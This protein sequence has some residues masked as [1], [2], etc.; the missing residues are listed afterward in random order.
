M[1]STIDLVAPLEPTFGHFSANQVLTGMIAELEWGILVHLLPVQNRE[2]RVLAGMRRLLSVVD[3]SCNFLSVLVDPSSE[4]IL[5]IICTPPHRYISTHV[6]RFVS[7]YEEFLSAVI[8]D[9]LHI[10]FITEEVVL[11]N[12]LAVE[13]VD[14]LA[15][16]THKTICGFQ[17][18]L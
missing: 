6:D 2:R 10:L 14:F 17:A 1:S 5:V 16:T 12:R 8:T 3:A 9:D 11:N 4:G 18:G 7:L 15:D 13:N